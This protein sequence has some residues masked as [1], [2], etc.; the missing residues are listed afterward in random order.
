[1]AS[2]VILGAGVMGSALAVPAAEQGN[3]VLLAGSPLDDAIIDALQAGEQHPGLQC[4]LPPS[5]TP[6]R[7]SALS[8]Q[9]IAAADVVVLGG[10]LSR[11]RLGGRSPA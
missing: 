10:E 2:I 9:Q 6:V 8:A 11:H 3:A 7:E 1:M 5:I 4:D